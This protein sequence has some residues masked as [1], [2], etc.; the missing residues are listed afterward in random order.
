[1][2]M[3]SEIYEGGCLCGAVRYR[4]Q[5]APD[6]ADHC[7]CEMCRRHGGVAFETWV[8]FPS[9]R[10]AWTK[11]APKVYVSSDIAERGFCARCGSPLTFQYKERRNLMS[12]TLGSLDSPQD[13]AP[14][15]H[16]WHDARISW[17]HLDE[18]L[19][20]YDRE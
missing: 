12:V 5:G 17:L 11:G 8:S 3:T 10:L 7:H 2:T 13:I 15:G 6:H 9:D 1:M 16:N 20:R 19:P 14:E 4:A 18:H